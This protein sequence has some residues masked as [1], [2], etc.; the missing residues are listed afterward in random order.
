LVATTVDGV[1]RIPM[2]SS[3]YSSPSS[4]TMVD[5]EESSTKRHRKM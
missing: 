4:L 5:D 3:S 2:Q 1:L